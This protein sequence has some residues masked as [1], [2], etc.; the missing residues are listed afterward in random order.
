L[1][2]YAFYEKQPPL[3]LIYI[4]GLIPKNPLARGRFC[5]GHKGASSGVLNP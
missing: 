5:G 2:I 4:E 1:V 3:S